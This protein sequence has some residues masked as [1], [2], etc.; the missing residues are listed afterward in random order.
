[1]NNSFVVN[2]YPTPTGETDE[3]LAVSTAVVSLTNAWSSAK[4]KY[5]LI[6]IQGDDVMV[7][8]DGSNP[9]STNGHLFKKLT[10]PFFWNKNTAMA[11]KFIRA[12]ATDASV[13]ATPF[14]V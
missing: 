3:R 7:T 2:L 8:F 14:T 11:A 9:S 6:D 12:N 10:P 5:V 4:T 13:Q 1:M